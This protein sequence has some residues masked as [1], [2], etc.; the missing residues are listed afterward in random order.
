MALFVIGLAGLTVPAASAEEPETTEVEA[1]PS[2][3]LAMA[4][5]TVPPLVRFSGLVRLPDAQVS[6]G[7]AASKA[8]PHAIAITFALYKDQE[9]GV[10]LW[11]ETQTVAVEAGGRYTVLLGAKEQLP[12]ELFTA[13]EARWLGVRAE[14]A[15]EQAR[16]LLVSVPYAL[17]AADAE[18][19]GGKPL[20]SFVLQEESTTGFAPQREKSKS[21]GEASVIDP[22]AT[23]QVISGTAGRIAKFTGP[24]PDDLGDSVMFESAGNIGI[25]T[26]SPASI[27]NVSSVSPELRMT[28]TSSV[29]IPQLTFYDGATLGG[30]FQFRNSGVADPNIFR[31][32]GKASGSQFAIVTSDTE[33][34]RVDASGRV[35]IGTT[36]PASI[37]H[38]SA[39][40]PELRLTSTSSVSI[41][42]LS[43]YDG[44]TLGG[45]FQ[46]RNS[47][48]AD[49][50]IFSLGGKVAGSQFAIHAGGSEKVRVTAAGNVGI[51]TTSPVGKLQVA[52]SVRA[53]AYQDLSGNPVASVAG[54]I[55]GITLLVGC[56]TCSPLTDADDQPTFYADVIGP[57]TIN[58]VTCFSD[59]G[60]PSINLQRN[61]GT[62]A[63]ILTPDLVCST[64]G[65]TAT[66]LNLVGT[67]TTLQLNNTLDF[68]MVAAGGS[69]KR[70]TVVIKA[71]VN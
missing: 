1:T 11:E 69:A 40:S 71:T 17:K 14:G 32:G 65:A 9:G 33:K 61:D 50:N 28:S 37:L 62:P 48:V 44:A 29:S 52:G 22:G 16:I 34:V 45:F 57:M 66:G 24:N 64:S 42:Q 70:V 36:T 20:S 38:L 12:M 56:E 10:A 4:D 49:P 41:P 58:S 21:S 54:L 13:N 51:G 3:P 30:F 23:P 8:W 25:G 35:G 2:L 67:E 43:F 68:V 5:G 6:T 60:T 26:T 47:G 55:R 39:T 27:L 53:S 46:Y 7:K 59:A 18:T 15:G 19:L 31:L 63:N